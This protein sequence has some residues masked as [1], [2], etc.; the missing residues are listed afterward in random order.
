MS[1]EPNT[2]PKYASFFARVVASVIDSIVL[3]VFLIPIIGGLSEIFFADVDME[4]FRHNLYQTKHYREVLILLKESGV[5]AKVQF[6]SIAQLFAFSIFIILFWSYTSSTPGKMLLKMVIVDANTLEKPTK[7]QW[8]LRYL[9]YFVSV[10][11][12]FIGFAWVAL[13][14][15]RQGWHDKIAG[16]VVIHEQKK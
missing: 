2:H 1:T 11:S 6:E 8:T 3:G 5:L 7:K 9:G 16:T 4:L 12:I 14:K 10:L 13:D 15:K